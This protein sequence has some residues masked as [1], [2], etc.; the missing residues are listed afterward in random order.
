MFNNLEEFEYKRSPEEA[1]GFYLVY[2]LGFRAIG[3]ILGPM[4]KMSG[5]MGPTQQDMM[6]NLH[7]F[8]MLIAIAYCCGLAVFILQ[9]KKMEGWP[10]WALVFLTGLAA[11]IN[12][13]VGMAVV[14]YMTTRPMHWPTPEAE[15]QRR[16]AAKAAR[17]KAARRA[18]QPSQSADA[19]PDQPNAAAAVV[20]AEESVAPS[21]AAPPAKARPERRRPDLLDEE[22]EEQKDQAAKQ[23]PVQKPDQPA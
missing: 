12:G 10:G 17:M 1:L 18:R 16:A 11:I 23:P 14:A 19:A 6:R 22:T 3:F 15:L 7:V 13:V 8:G 20:K 4:L 21:P 5:M 2:T 9:R